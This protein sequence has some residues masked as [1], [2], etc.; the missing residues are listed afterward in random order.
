MKKN[1][2]QSWVLI[3]FVYLTWRE[4]FALAKAPLTEDGTLTSADLTSSLAKVLRNSYGFV[5]TKYGEPL[6]VLSQSENTVK[7]QYQVSDQFTKGTANWKFCLSITLQDIVNWHFLW[8]K[9]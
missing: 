9:T 3:A 4:P 5:R 6:K 1:L 7:A 2:I 8:T